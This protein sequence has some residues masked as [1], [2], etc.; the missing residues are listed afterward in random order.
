M[1]RK[2]YAEFIA[3]REEEIMASLKEKVGFLRGLSGDPSMWDAHSFKSRTFFLIFVVDPMAVHR[4]KEAGT[5]QGPGFG[6]LES[7]IQ[8]SR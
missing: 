1:K 8:A 5:N 6:G 7:K 2:E 3:A 4:S